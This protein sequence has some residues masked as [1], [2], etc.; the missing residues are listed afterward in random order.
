MIK[1]GRNT[2]NNISM[3][4]PYETRAE[5]DVASCVRTMRVLLKVW[6]NVRNI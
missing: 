2:P 3:E 4:Q 5:F 6:K 1:E